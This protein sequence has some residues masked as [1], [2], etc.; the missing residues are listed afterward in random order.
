MGG[1][2]SRRAERRAQLCMKRRAERRAQLCMKR[3]DD[4]IGPD[5]DLV[6]DHDDLMAV[7]EAQLRMERRAEREAQLCMKRMA[8]R[9]VE[10]FGSGLTLMNDSFIRPRQRS[11]PRVVDF[12]SDVSAVKDFNK[13][14]D[15]LM[16]VR[17]AR[18]RMLRRALFCPC[19]LSHTPPHLRLGDFSS[20]EKK[21]VVSAVEKW[22]KPLDDQMAVRRAQLC[23]KRWVDFG[24]DVSAVKDFNKLL[25]DLMAVRRAWLRMERRAQCCHF[26]PCPC[27]DFHLPFHLRRP[28]F[29]HFGPCPWDD[30]H[31]PFL[32]RMAEREAQLRRER[33]WEIPS[34]VKKLVVSAVDDWI[35]SLDDQF[36]RMATRSKKS[37]YADVSMRSDPTIPIRC[38]SL[39]RLESI[40]S[41]DFG[42]P[43]GI[44]RYSS[45]PRLVDFGSDVSAGEVL[46]KISGDLMATGSIKSFDSGVSLKSEQSKAEQFDFKDRVSPRGQET[47][48]E[49]G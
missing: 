19:D 7:R 30:F 38:H 25:D 14:L 11:L 42:V 24:S 9:S 13:L 5:I 22:I 3:P 18:L 47:N 46:K 21:L 37:N 12:D 35:N 10:A 49:V 15:D 1:N 23:M 43:F 16:A 28:P 39:P 20:S 29:C 4:L 33:W 17:R 36:T 41:S 8:H 45:L 32:P 2:S 34:S 48:Q 40:E 44:N 6:G 26:G 27:D 31:G